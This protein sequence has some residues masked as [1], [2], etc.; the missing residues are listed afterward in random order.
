LAGS[1][2]QWRQ[3]Q[4]KTIAL[5]SKTRNAF[6]YQRAHEVILQRILDTSRLV[7]KDGRYELWDTPDG[8][9]WI[10]AGE[11]WSLADELAEEE[12]H[13]YEENFV[14]IPSS[15]AHGD[16]RRRR[17][18]PQVPSTTDPQLLPRTE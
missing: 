1:R 12:F 3:R 2:S 5:N 10:I 16:S 8:R 11:V 18:D 7:Q 14:T 6:T 13:V 17:N 4:W 9:Y 15:R